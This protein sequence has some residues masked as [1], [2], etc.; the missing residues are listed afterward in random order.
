M[1]KMYVRFL[2]SL[3]S[4]IFNLVLKNQDTEHSLMLFFRDCVLGTFLK[5]DNLF[6]FVIHHMQ[7]TIKIK[8]VL[9]Q[10]VSS[11]AIWCVAPE[12]LA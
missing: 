8:D 3:N 12:A 5:H 2:C 11:K 7:L 9:L 6:H 4:L 1:L 10:K